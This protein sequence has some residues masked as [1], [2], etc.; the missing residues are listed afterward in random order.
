M[1]LLQI[2]NERFQIF[3][4]GNSQDVFL[5]SHH[6]S[7][8]TEGTVRIFKKPLTSQISARIV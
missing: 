4:P 2:R 3:T 8:S 5:Q 7:P 1:A 6:Q